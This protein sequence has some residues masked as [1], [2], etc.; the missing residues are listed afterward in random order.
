[1]AGYDLSPIWQQLF[2][3]ANARRRLAQV[4]PAFGF[5]TPATSVED[6]LR[7]APANFWSVVGSMP[8]LGGPRVPPT[9]SAPVTGSSP[10][11]SVLGSIA[12]DG[13]LP[14]VQP[15]TRFGPDGRP[16]IIH[17]ADP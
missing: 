14:T 11:R 16:E 17:D 12:S 9:A 2:G 8:G 3:D 5:P 1:M 13:R 4:P 7:K 10:L 6:G 15:A